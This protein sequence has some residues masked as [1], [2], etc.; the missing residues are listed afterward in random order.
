ML[1]KCCF[2]LGFIL[3]KKKK[4]KAGYVDFGLMHMEML[5]VQFFKTKL[6]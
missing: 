2:C 4:V 6:E 5:R 3:S 1:D